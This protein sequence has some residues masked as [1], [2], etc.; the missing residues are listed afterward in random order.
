M[1]GTMKE[2]I[3]RKFYRSIIAQNPPK[4]LFESKNAIFNKFKREVQV[5]RICL[6]NN[7]ECKN[8]SKSGKEPNEAINSHS[9]PEKNLK[10]MSKKSKVYILQ[11]D[12]QNPFKNKLSAPFVKSALTF[13]GFCSYHDRNLFSK[14][15]NV[16]E[17]HYDNNSIFLISYRAL[18]KAIVESTQLV[19]WLEWKLRNWDSVEF[20]EYNKVIRKM[21][22]EE[23]ILISKDVFYKK[24]YLFMILFIQIFKTKYLEKYKQIRELKNV[25]KEI[26]D[27]KKKLGVYNDLINSNQIFESY[28]KVI[29]NEKTIAFSCILNL[30][31]QKRD[32][33]VYITI[34]PTKEGSDLIISCKK[35]DF[36]YISSDKRLIDLFNGD[37]NLVNEILNISKSE[38][39][40]NIEDYESDFGHSFFL[41][42]NIPLA[43]IEYFKAKKC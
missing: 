9:I 17:I 27:Y 32:V 35:N 37:E 33:F 12:F 10:Y 31:I 26:R 16:E 5:K 38:I 3:S 43:N 28:F 42:W 7:D 14:I 21:M 2:K 24:A 1:R 36:R 29:K 18:S 22:L 34:I 30:K 11:T 25:K 13:P 23:E 41:E 40:H 19:E 4:E 8:D 15:E 6:L 20:T 39:A